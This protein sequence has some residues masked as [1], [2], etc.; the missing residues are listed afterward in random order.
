MKN[1]DDS[2]PR[3]AQQTHHFIIKYVHDTKNSIKKTYLEAIATFPYPKLY[4]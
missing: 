2:L 3:R 4:I 1:S